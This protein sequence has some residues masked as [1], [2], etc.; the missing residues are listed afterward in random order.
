MEST[1]THPDDD[2]LDLATLWAPIGGP[3]PGPDQRSLPHRGR[4]LSSPTTQC[5]P[6]PPKAPSR[7]HSRR[8][9]ARVRI[10][11]PHRTRRDA[12]HEHTPTTR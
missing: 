7:T 12:A 4:R 6:L 8:S 3:T 1:V 9:R 5:N 2:I 11:D 10:L